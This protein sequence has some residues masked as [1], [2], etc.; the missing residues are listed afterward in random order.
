MIIDKT[1][2]GNDCESNGENTTM[3]VVLDSSYDNVKLDI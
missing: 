1:S 2:S 3:L